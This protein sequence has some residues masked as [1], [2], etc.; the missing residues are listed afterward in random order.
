MLASD[1]A[2]WRCSDPVWIHYRTLTKLEDAVPTDQQATDLKECFVNV[3]S[4]LV[5][6]AHLLRDPNADTPVAAAQSFDSPANLACSC[7]RREPEQLQ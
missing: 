6:H 2:W 1:P 7:S 3:V 4:L 5:S